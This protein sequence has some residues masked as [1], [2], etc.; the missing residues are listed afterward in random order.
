MVENYRI[1][2]LYKEVLASKW[3]HSCKDRCHITHS[4]DKKRVISSVLINSKIALAFVFV[5]VVIFV[6]LVCFVF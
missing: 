3:G 5:F 6:F 4:L 1:H 2:Q